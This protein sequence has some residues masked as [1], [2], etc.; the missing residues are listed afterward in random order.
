M[1]ENQ[2]VTFAATIL[3]DDV[4]PATLLRVLGALWAASYSEGKAAGEE[5]AGHESTTRHSS[6]QIAPVIGAAE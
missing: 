6:S 4:R 2:L 5:S 3:A 1:S